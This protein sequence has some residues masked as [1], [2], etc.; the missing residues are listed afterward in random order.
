MRLDLAARPGSTISRLWPPVLVALA[1]GLA[2]EAGVRV[3]DVAPNV[4]PSPSRIATVTWEE[5]RPLLGDSWVTAQEAFLGLGLAFLVAIVVA[6]VL[7]HSAGVRRAIEPLLIGS[8][9]LPIVAIAPLFI[10]WFDFGLL[11]KVFTVAL[12]TFFPIV[13][14]LGRGFRAADPHA[15]ALIRTMGGNGG[16]VLRRV[17]V[18]SALPSMFTGLRLAA[19]YSVVAAVISEFLGA[20]DGLGITMQE[21]NGT[22]QTDLLFA[23]VSATFVLTMVIIAFVAATERLVA[24]WAKVTR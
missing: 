20:F 1:V 15:E 16:D 5:R 10:L 21:A 12:Y 18:P 8:Q 24:P 6:L 13:V 19:T 4:L 17:R 11:G 7:D 22:R 9:I 23:S 2:W 14:G 3:A